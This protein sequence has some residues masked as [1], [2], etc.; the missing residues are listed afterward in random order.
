MQHLDEG[1]LQ[2]WLDGARS[3]LDPSR[4]A[5]IERHL[6]ACSA[7]A[8]RADVLAHS[9]FRAHALLAVGR[10]QYAPRVPYEDVAKRAHPARKRRIP[11]TWAA[12]IAA[13]L[14][15]GWVSNELYRAEGAAVVETAEVAAVGAAATPTP[16]ATARTPLAASAPQGVP[17][18]EAAGVLASAPFADAGPSAM[19]SDGLLVRGFVADEGGRPVA[20]AQVFVAE[21]DVGVLTQQD[22]R[23]DLRLPAEPDEFELTVQRIGFRQQARA[24]SA[25]EGDY[26]DADFRLREEAL[27]L[28]EIVVTGESYG[29]Q[30]RS[31]GNAVTSPRATPFAWRPLSSIAAEGNVGSDLWMLPGLDLLT[32]EVA[33]GD[34]PNE[35]YVARVRQD[36]GQGGTL[37][38]IQGRTDQR[39]TGWPIQSAGVVQSTWRGEMLITATAPVSSDS[40]RTLLTH[41]R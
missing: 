1:T 34:N 11:A 25:G 38:L 18:G 13:A 26:V 16:I 29:T 9:S 32:L 8:S 33:L 37:T 23:Y 5:A 30:R 20:A 24:I 7:C 2:A 6:A 22:G 19:D 41:L 12:S 28:D 21:L 10:A 35:T 3:G 39:R 40:L 31:T 27:T 15:V 17:F 4:L 14:A 36:L